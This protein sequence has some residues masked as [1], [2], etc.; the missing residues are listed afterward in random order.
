M[1]GD[2]NTGNVEDPEHG[3]Q[4]RDVGQNE[5]VFCMTLYRSGALLH[6]VFP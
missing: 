2:T 5:V 6:P 4:V 1:T 3:D